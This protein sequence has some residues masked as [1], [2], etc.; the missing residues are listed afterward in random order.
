MFTTFYNLILSDFGKFEDNMNF[1]EKLNSLIFIIFIIATFLNIIIMLNLLISV[2]SDVFAKVE[3]MA[4]NYLNFERLQIISSIDIVLAGEIK[5]DLEKQ[6]DN[7]YLFVS[8]KK[9]SEDE[10]ISTNQMRVKVENIE[11]IVIYFQ[12]FSLL[13]KFI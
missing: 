4:K 10:S 1:D 11:R 12:F 13:I 2:V 3:A 5:K 9:I 7:A 8:R 6:F